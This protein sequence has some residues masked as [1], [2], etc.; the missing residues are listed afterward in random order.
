MAKPS[1]SLSGPEGWDWTPYKSPGARAPLP[2]RRSHGVQAGTTE[3]TLNR[4]VARNPVEAT[5]GEEV[6][7]GLRG[8]K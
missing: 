8:L 4:E 3:A 2:P 5:E 7:S 6:G 1:A